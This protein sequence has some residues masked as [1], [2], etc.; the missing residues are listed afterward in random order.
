[1]SCTVVDNGDGT[2]T[3]TC[4]DGTRVTVRD[5]QNAASA[6]ITDRHG[7]DFMQSTGEYANGKYIANAVITSAT[8]D[9]AG[10]V[11]VNFRV[12]RANNTAVTDVPSVTANIANRMVGVLGSSNIP[13]VLIVCGSNPS[14]FYD[15]LAAGPIAAN[16]HLPM[17]AVRPTSIPA[18]VQNVLDGALLGKPRYVV[19]STAYVSNS[20]YNS[21]GAVDRFT[22][23]ADR[24]T[25]S[26]DI[27]N[28]AVDTYGWL[29][30]RETAI[31]AK[32]PDALTGG[33]FIGKK[34]SALLF[35]DS[36]TVMK[37]VPKSW[38]TSK[39]AGILRGW[40]L[41]GPASVTEQV[42]NEYLTLIQ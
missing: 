22:T 33:A 7:E 16:K 31:A 17:L 5:G 30:P 41:G 4:E 8:A 29:T 13:G 2:K 36:T 32:L 19:S 35:T 27:A 15:A 39:K 12:T 37:S 9:A 14:A 34:G 40:V 23:S 42:K 38:I 26:R 20:V 11:T 28:K 1:M 25:A 10:V 6:L 3:I 18:T 21:V 24:Y